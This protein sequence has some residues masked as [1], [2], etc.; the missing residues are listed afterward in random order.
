MRGVASLLPPRAARPHPENTSRAWAVSARSG[1]TPEV[2]SPLSAC[3]AARVRWTGGFPGECGGRAVGVVV[4]PQDGCILRPSRWD[5][6]A[7]WLRGRPPSRATSARRG[8]SQ[9]AS[10]APF[11]GRILAAL[12]PNHHRPAHGQGRL[13]HFVSRFPTGTFALTGSGRSSLERS[14]S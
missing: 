8:S 1:L 4:V 12:T 2:G 3:G 7:L 11:L 5:G 10:A 9:A 14:G 13:S 6:V